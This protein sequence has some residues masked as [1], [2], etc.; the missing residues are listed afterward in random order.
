M[1]A[2]VIVWMITQKVKLKYSVALLFILL[3]LPFIA[4]QA[5]PTFHNRVKYFLYDF[6]Y[7]KETHYLPGANDAVRVISLKAGWNVM[8]SQ[9]VIGVGFGD[10]LSETKK[11]YDG[12]IPKM[13]EADKIYPSGE[14]MIYGTGCGWV[15]ILLFSFVMIIPFWIKTGNHLLWWLLNATAAFGFLF[16]IGLEVQFGVFIYS[17]I[18]LWWWKWLS[19]QQ[20][21]K[22]M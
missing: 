21:E 12:N 4:Y 1:L 19:P 10:I 22:K 13:L 20:S 8:N 5:L 3:A 11:W 2:G 14:W 18:V 6:G 16:D 9:P 7:F 17:F 15:G